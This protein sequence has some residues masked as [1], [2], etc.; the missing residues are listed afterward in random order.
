MSDSVASRFLQNNGTGD[1]R[2]LALQ[3]FSGLVLE[4]FQNK[5]VFY[6]NTGNIIQHKT[7][8]G[9]HSAQFPIMGDDIDLSAAASG[10]GAAKGYHTPGTFLSGS[11]VKLSKKNIEVDDI[12]V[13]SMDVGYA[14]LDIAHFDVLGPFAMK[15]GRSLAKDCD[16]KICTTALNAARSAGLS[17]VYPGGNV[18]TRAT[19]TNPSITVAYDN[20]STGSGNFRNDCAQ[21]ARLMDEDN[22]PED[23]RY[24]FISPYIRSILRHETQIF[25][26]DFNDGS[27]VGS[28]NNRVIG[29]L[30]GFNLILTNHIPTATV[31]GYTGLGAKYNFTIDAT[32]STATG[33]SDLS[34]CGASQVGHLLATPVAVALCGAIDGSAG[35][36][37]VQASGIRSVMQDDERRNTKFLKSQMMV[38][39][40]VLAPWCA[41]SIEVFTA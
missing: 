11:T 20:S 38:G 18:V 15:L 13:A 37:M 17:G 40:D 12:L 16:K 24:L 30:E 14:D 41:G 23:G 29:A 10:T 33:A 32:G 22:V 25:N 7:L 1:N 39:F 34:N 27:V 35:V 28:M 4:A 8:S 6:D 3:M 19:S 36:G 5:T 21:L 31:S 9:S 2:A 26:R